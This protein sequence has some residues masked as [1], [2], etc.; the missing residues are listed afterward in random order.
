MAEINRLLTDKPANCKAVVIG[1][2]ENIRHYKNEWVFDLGSQKTPEIAAA[3]Y[4][5][6][7]FCDE[8][9]VD[10]IY[11]EGVPSQGVG[12]AVA[13]RLHKATGGSVIHVS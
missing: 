10:M 13:N 6:L 11:I 1:T 3:R 7:R 12:L 9:T 4:D 2:T 5:L 8:L